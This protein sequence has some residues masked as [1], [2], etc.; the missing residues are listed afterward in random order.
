MN[1]NQILG[2]V[3]LVIGV[4]LFGFG[5]NSTQAVS[6]KVVEGVSGRYTEHTMLYIVGGLAMMVGGAA[7]A[8]G[9]RNSV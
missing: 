6:E 3:I 2:L 7:L 8:F 4:I 5:I 1:I 9:K